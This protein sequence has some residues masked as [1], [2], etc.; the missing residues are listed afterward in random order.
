MIDSDNSSLS[1]SSQCKLLRISRSGLYYQCRGENE[2]NLKLMS[3]ID[4]QYLKT[5]YYGSRQ[6]SRHLKRLGY[7][8]GRHRVRRLMRKMGIEAIYQKPNTTPRC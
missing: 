8:V 7:C 4:E 5:P 3:L 6:M 1:I 2:L